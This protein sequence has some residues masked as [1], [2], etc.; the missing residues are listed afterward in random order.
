MN[1]IKSI[2]L[3]ADL[4]EGYPYDNK[5]FPLVSS[6]NIACGGHAGDENSIRESLRQCL[7]HDVAAGA[8]PSYPD[9]EN[10]G[11]KTMQLNRNFLQ[12]SIKTQLDIFCTIASKENI[13]PNHVKLHG[14]LYNDCFDNI[15]LSEQVLEVIRPY[16]IP[17]FYGPSMSGLNKIAEASG[18]TAIQEVFADR[19]YLASGKLAPRSNPGSVLHDLD[20]VSKQLQSLLIH[21]TVTTMEGSDIEL[22]SDT[23]CLHGDNDQ[24]VAFAKKIRELLR[25]WNIGIRSPRN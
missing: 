15:E 10:F 22:K 4:G 3:N 8:H 19:A 14:A 6:A 18:M 21:H 16:D 12:D 17:F 1:K 2:D 24:A 9:K 11:R 25:L 5:L 13:K 23:V 20:Q 7:L